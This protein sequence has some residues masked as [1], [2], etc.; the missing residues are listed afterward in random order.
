MC[1]EPCMVGPRCP[2][3][4]RG[5]QLLAELLRGEFVQMGPD[6]CDNM[7]WREDV[8][9]YVLIQCTPVHAIQTRDYSVSTSATTSGQCTLIFESA[10]LFSF[11]HVRHSVT[12]C[13]NRACSILR[14][15]PKTSTS[16]RSLKSVRV[17]RKKE[18]TSIC[19]RWPSWTLDSVMPFRSM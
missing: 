18:N 4:K 9:R 11:H 8:D 14:H 17:R 19:F 12:L 5:G 2:V 10:A 1:N 15:W 7:R 13:A 3:G 16:T 6:A